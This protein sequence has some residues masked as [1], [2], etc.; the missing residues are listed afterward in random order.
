MYFNIQN[1]NMLK[2]CLWTDGELNL[3]RNFFGGLLRSPAD[4]CTTHRSSMRLK[5]EHVRLNGKT[6][7]KRANEHTDNII[8]FSVLYPSVLMNPFTVPSAKSETISPICRKLVC[9]AILKRKL[10]ICA[11][12][13]S[14]ICGIF[15]ES[16]KV[17]E[18]IMSWYSRMFLWTALQRNPT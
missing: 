2:V 10:R 15:H 16:A 9:W 3:P 17:V 4:G 5:K 1:L 7:N 13:K 18:T 14:S 12:Q 8:F 6:Q 11:R